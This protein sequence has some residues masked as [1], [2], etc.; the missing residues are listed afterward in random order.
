MEI[1]STYRRYL[2][3]LSQQASFKDNICSNSLEK[4][5]TRLNVFNYKF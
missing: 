3:I 2:D 1:Y 4:L 5:K